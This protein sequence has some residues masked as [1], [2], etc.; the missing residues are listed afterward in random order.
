[1]VQCQTA[2][3]QHISV[4]RP[5]QSQVVV[6]MVLAF[7][8][9]NRNLEEKVLS[10]EVFGLVCENFQSYP[11]LQSGINYSCGIYILFFACSTL[12]RE[13]NASLL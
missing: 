5:A 12:Q 8:A 3:N 11:S 6:L 13:A 9:L 4:I 10:R 2:V 7:E 1:M